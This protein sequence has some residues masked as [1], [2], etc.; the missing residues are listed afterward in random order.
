M[1][2]YVQVSIATY[3]YMTKY[4]YQDEDPWLRGNSNTG[5][6]GQGSIS[7]KTYMIKWQY[8]HGHPWTSGNFITGIHD[9]KRISTVW[10]MT[11]CEYEHDDPWPCMIIKMG[12]MT[13]WEYQCMT[14]CEYQEWDTWMYSLVLCVRASVV[15]VPPWDPAVMHILSWLS[16][17]Y[18]PLWAVL[19]L[20]WYS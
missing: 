7:R 6:L 3:V 12:H 19:S 11:K 16:K 5:I 2:I 17:E 14:K 15:E 20:D 1:E 10:L 13:K 4:D 8:Q 9:Q 18:H